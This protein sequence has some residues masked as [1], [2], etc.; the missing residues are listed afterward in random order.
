MKRVLFFVLCSYTSMALSQQIALNSQY[1]FNEISFNPGAAGSKEYVAIHANARQQWLGFEGAPSSQTLSGHG[2]VGKSMG[3]GGTIYNEVTGPSRRTGFQVMG[4]YRLKLSSDGSHMLGMGLGLSM[5]QHLID[6]NRLTTYLP[7]D[8]AIL[9]GFNNKMV[10]DANVG[11]FY[12]FKNKAFAGISARNLLQ[13]DVDLFDY[14]IKVVNPMVR[15]YYAYGGYNFGLP[16]KWTL[17]PSA[18]FRMIDALAMSFDVSVLA[19]YNNKVWF[20]ASYRYEDAVVAM[21]GIQFGVFKFGYSYD[22]TLSDIKNYSA[23]SH[24][25]FLELQVFG[26]EK[27][28]SSSSKIPWLKRN[29]IYTPSL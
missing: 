14:E 26:K 3:F 10:P 25:I 22:F 11:F 2:Y 6:A 24:E 12:T 17:T 21:A 7:E 13:T 8:P 20:G 28:G 16:K 19:N 18:M 4:A 29:R 27:S 1:M 9:K 23:G 5:T 15:N